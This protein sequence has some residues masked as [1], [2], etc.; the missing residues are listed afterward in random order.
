MRALS[1]ACVHG[2]AGSKISSEIVGALEAA[3]ITQGA[4]LCVL[5]SQVFFKA[6]H[7]QV[8]SFGALLYAKV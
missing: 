1:L 8:D 3:M 5:P 2:T 6:M 4:C 7:E